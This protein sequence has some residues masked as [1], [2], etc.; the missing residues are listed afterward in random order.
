MQ[1]SGYQKLTLLDYPNRLACIIFLQGCN[2]NC[3][4]CQNSE[5]IT[6]KALDPV[7][8][9]EI[10]AFLGKRKSVLEGVVITGGEP[11]LNSDV[12]DFIKDIKALGYKI[13]IDTN[14][15]NPKLLKKLID[16]K[17][18]DYVA[19]DIK[20][21]PEKYAM[22]C[23][24]S[25]IFIEHIMQ[26]IVLIKESGIEHEFRTTICKDF[27]TIEDIRKMLEMVKGSTYFVQ[28]F[29]VS[30]YVRNKDLKPFTKE[31]L[32][33]IKKCLGDEYKNLYI[34]NLEH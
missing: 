5:I 24:I 4:Y 34:R 21:A 9:E 13:K 15:T 11:L 10:M 30:E 6:N 16:E 17:L 23:G 29:E 20:N 2:L 25:S 28:N 7:P 22:T 33:N 32:I 8:K 27:H 26:C 19:M 1:I 12:K 3:P 14:G 31:E 18:I